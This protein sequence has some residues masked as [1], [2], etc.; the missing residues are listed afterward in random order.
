M[1]PRVGQVAWAWV[2]PEVQTS[3]PAHNEVTTRALLTSSPWPPVPRRI[4]HL[5]ILDKIRSHV[6][7]FLMI[8]TVTHWAGLVLSPRVQSCD[9]DLL[10]INTT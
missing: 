3:D 2:A 6:W 8:M 10:E 7:Q 9:N 4:K 5:V 1:R